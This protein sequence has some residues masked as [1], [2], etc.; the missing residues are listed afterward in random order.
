MYNLQKYTHIYTNTHYFGLWNWLLCL[1][2][3]LEITLP[4]FFL[5]S[6][7][8]I[9]KKFKIFTTQKHRSPKSCVSL[10]LSPLL[11]LLM[12]TRSKK[13]KQFRQLPATILLPPSPSPSMSKFHS[14]YQQQ[15]PPSS[16]SQSSATTPNGA[17]SGG[18]SDSSSCCSSTASIQTAITSSSTVTAVPMEVDDAPQLFPMLPPPV[19]LV[20]GVGS[21]SYKP[22]GAGSSLSLAGITRHMRITYSNHSSTSH[23][24]N[25]TT[26]STNITSSNNTATTAF[27][28]STGTN[29]TLFLSTI[30]LRRLRSSLRRHSV[31]G[32][33]L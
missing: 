3:G 14:Y 32:I 28:N 22:P 1:K 2:F 13:Y 24:T 26:G 5:L 20:V 27:S 7:I 9:R 18:G 25:T 21:T 23:A 10:S 11:T 31:S 4:P 12:C 30:P 16:S 15:R 33:S 6:K 8:Y 19:P 29:N 17:G